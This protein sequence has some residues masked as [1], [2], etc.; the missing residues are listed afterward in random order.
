MSESQ[1]LAELTQAWST[2]QRYAPLRRIENTDALERVHALASM[3]ADT[4]GDDTSHPLYSLFELLMN[5]IEQWEDEHLHLPNA[6]PRDVLRCLLE[7]N[8]LEPTDLGDVAAPELLDD[9][10]SGQHDID[11]DLAKALSRRFHID[12][13]AFI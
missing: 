8:D 9:I 4:V 11:E 1:E 5:L 10:L 13:K 6:K 12:V 2:L 3:L 7:A